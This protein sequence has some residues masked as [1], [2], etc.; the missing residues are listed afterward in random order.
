MNCISQETDPGYVLSEG[1]QLPALLKMWGSLGKKLLNK[2]V[3]ESK[4]EEWLKFIVNEK[5][6]SALFEIGRELISPH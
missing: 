1:I 5:R 3:G 6:L 4:L 2:R